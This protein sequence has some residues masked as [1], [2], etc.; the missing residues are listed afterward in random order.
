MLKIRV[1]GIG[2]DKERWVTDACA[3]FSKL[4]SRF[5]DIEWILIPSLK[6]SSSLS[7][8]EIK[9]KEAAVIRKEIKKGLV[10]ALTDK[11]TT[12]DSVGF[13]GFLETCM[14]TNST[15]NFI[16][17]GPYGLNGS[18]LEKVDY[19]LSLSPLTFS[20]QIVRLILVEQLY[21]A[22]SI[23]HGTDYHK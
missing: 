1:V 11:G 10:I 16:I 12:Y 8:I 4:L 13:A 15:V 6:L 21:R 5:A 20:H 3:H 22:F 23:I 7:R 18:I 9:K 14:A 17:G 19:K 2:K